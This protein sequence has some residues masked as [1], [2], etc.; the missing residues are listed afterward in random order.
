MYSFIKSN[1]VNQIGQITFLVENF[2]LI[3]GILLTI[4]ALRRTLEVHLNI[5]ALFDKSIEGVT[6]HLIFHRVTLDFLLKL[7][8]QIVG[9]L[10]AIHEGVFQSGC[11]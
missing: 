6:N 11:P 5:H 1:K 10:H 4:E 3:A 7:V 8:L 9:I 2:A